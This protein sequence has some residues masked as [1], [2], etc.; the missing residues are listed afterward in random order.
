MAP[1]HDIRTLHLVDL[2]NLVGDP[3]AGKAEALGALD[4]YL[5]LA[6]Y[7]RGDQVIIAANPGMICEVGFDIPVPCNQHAARGKDGAD[8]VLLSHIEPSQVAVRFDRLVIGSGDGEFADTAIAVRDCGA[9]VLVVTRR[10]SLSNR[11]QGVG[12]GI[13][14]LPERTFAMAC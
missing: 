1:T 13:R 10:R 2:E 8:L 11:L 3:M 9:P 4:Q 7:R 6:D 5:D 12:L 14:F